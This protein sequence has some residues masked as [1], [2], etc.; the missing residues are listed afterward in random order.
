M[1]TST[2]CETA[3]RLLDTA[4]KLFGE[5]GSAYTSL[6]DITAA[7]GVNVAAVNYH[8]GSKH[9]LLTATF[10]R[11]MDPLNDERLRL[12]AEAE[13]AA[14]E[15][16]PSL[17]AILRSFVAPTVEMCRR[18]PEY[19]KFVSRMY[20]N[21]KEVHQEMIR[22]E[23]FR[24]L[25]A[26]LRRLLIKALPRSPRAEL[27]WRMNFVVGAMINTWHDWD[28]MEVLSRGEATYDGEEKVIDRLVAFACAGLRDAETAEEGE[29]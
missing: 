4:E 14:G 18:H 25:V 12:L 10:H 28:R 3:E 5:R 24:K 20:T 22:D 1:G 17:E 23:R 26:V 13:E 11:R 8:F 16:G 9:G 6:R 19:M 7:A 2:T 15:A 29:G 21:S 27:W